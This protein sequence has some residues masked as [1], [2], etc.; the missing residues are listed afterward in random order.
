MKGR[1]RIRCWSRRTLR[2]RSVG[3]MRACA[4]MRASTDGHP[5]PRGSASTKVHKSAGGVF[6]EKVMDNY[7]SLDS[8]SP[9]PFGAAE[10]P[11]GSQTQLPEAGGAQKEEEE[12]EERQ[13]QKQIGCHNYVGHNYMAYSY[14]Q[15]EICRS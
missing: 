8:R 11:T 12:E 10:I 4:R 14:G 9:D 5:P 7:V 6:F 3:R 1:M 13:H 2:S 15:K